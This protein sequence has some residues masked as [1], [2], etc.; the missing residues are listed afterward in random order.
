MLDFGDQNFRVKIPWDGGNS[1]ILVVA[2]IIMSFELDFVVFQTNEI[3]FH[4]MHVE[5]RMSKKN[6]IERI[7]NDDIISSIIYNFYGN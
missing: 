2:Q 6:A 5:I 1:P 4:I 3:V 7:L